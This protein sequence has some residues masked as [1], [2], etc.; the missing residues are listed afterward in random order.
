ML[1]IGKGMFIGGDYV[2][3]P[4]H[5]GRKCVFNNISGVGN[6]ISVDSMLSKRYARNG[7][8]PLSVLRGF[9]DM[10]LFLL[11]F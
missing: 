9:P 7:I 5:I 3:H 8:S 1:G 6:N 10:P 4:S 11:V 2:G